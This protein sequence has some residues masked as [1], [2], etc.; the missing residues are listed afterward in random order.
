MA[1][2]KPVKVPTGG[3]ASVRVV[4]PAARLN[5]QVRLALNEPPEGIAIQRVTPGPDGM[6]ILLRADGGKVKPGLKGNLIVD[7]FLEITP[8]AGA[9]NRPAT[10]RQPLG[11]LPAIPFEIVG[12]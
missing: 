8:K 2:D 12:L 4:L 3:S 11:T 7:A 9:G 1:A 6:S 10:R 5:G